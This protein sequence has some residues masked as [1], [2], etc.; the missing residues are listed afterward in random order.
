MLRRSCQL[1]FLLLGLIWGGCL[2]VLGQA[3]LDFTFDPTAPAVGEEVCFTAI[4][5]TGEPAWFVLFEWDYDQNGTYD[6]TGRDVCHSF[7]TEGTKTVTLRGT[8]DRGGFH[9][10]YHNVIVTN[11]QPTAE[12][13][14]EPTFPAAGSLVSF[15]GSPSFDADG[16][17]VSYEWDFGN[18]NDPGDPPDATGLTV[19]RAFATAGQHPVKL[20]V[21]DDGGA[22]GSVLH[23]VSVQPVSP[24]ACFEHDPLAPTVYDDILFMGDCSNDPDGGAIVLYSWSFGDG[25]FGTG[26]RVTHQYANGGVYEV[27]LTVTDDDQ[28]TDTT[29]E[30]IVVGGPS[31][32]FSYAPQS[33]TTQDAV[34]FFDQSSDTTG[35]IASW[36]WDFDDG[37]GSSVQNP[38]H[39]FA[40]SGPHRVR[41]T[42]TSE[43]GATSSVMR[44]ITVRNSPPTANYTFA[45]DTPDIDELVTFSAGGSS[46]PDGTIV[47]YEWDFDGDGLTDATGATVTHAFAIVG[48]RP[49]RLT[50][51]DNEGAPASLT[52]VVPV[53][54]SPPTACFTFTPPDPTTGEA[55]AFEGNCSNDAD[56]T[57]ILYEWDFDD[58]GATD[59]TGMAVTH[60]F[61]AAG[62]Y[63][64]TLMVTDNDGA[65]DADT[66]GVPVAT[67]GTSG[68]NQPPDPDFSITF[69]D[70]DEANIGEV[71][72]FLSDGSSDPDGTIVSYEWDFDNDGVYDATGTTASHVYH[73]GGAK[74]VTLRATD[75]D[76]AFGYKTRVVSVEFVRPTADFTFTPAQ[77]R[78]G[79]VVQ[80]DASPSTDRDGTVEFF[81]WDFDDDGQTDATG[82]TVTHVFPSGGAMPVTLTVIDDDGV[83]DF[84]TRTV[85]VEQNSPPVAD[86]T[87]EPTN[88]I[89]D[90][91]V[92]FRSTSTDVDGTIVAYHWDFGDDSPV[93]TTQTPSHSFSVPSPYTVTLT[94]TD[95][96][97]DTSQ[98][99]KTVIVYQASAEDEVVVDFTWSPQ[100]P[101]V[102]QQVQFSDASTDPRGTIDEWLW[103]FGD[104]TTS[105]AQDPTHQYATG[106]SYT[107][108]L[109]VTTAGGTQYP[110]SGPKTYTVVVGDLELYAFPNPT[111]VSARIVLGLARDATNIRLRIFDLKGSPVLDVQPSDGATEYL[112]NLQDAG[113]TVVGNGL[114][115]VLVTAKDAAGRAIRSEIFRLLIAR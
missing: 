87:F 52:K 107:V 77:P 51:T 43:G 95:D 27:S 58:D 35:D 44:T 49:V 40:V 54:A 47:I 37:G 33:P 1:A 91:L 8:D 94:I 53:Q 85:P 10:V 75:D 23:T 81:E 92:Q 98:V 39:V 7:P 106:G 76:G 32:A 38:L 30:T 59:A 70:G 18:D 67:G 105:T 64:V 55:V 108:T 115:F 11:E 24:I 83:A 114:Y 56:G 112:W 89:A 62:V 28:Q 104:G 6:A 13:T 19:R 73:T 31:A 86:F 68:D 109:R 50:V 4:V 97:G 78:N 69:A 93:T 22:T 41:L 57:I 80:F 17:I 79:E 48:A 111:S 16:V 88:P 63:P 12:F 45:P 42:V 34:Q 25:Q 72:T 96:G 103:N 29:T 113:G 61:P 90:Q 26:M 5:V 66:Q 9:F 3:T 36:T 46:D 84:T 71:V 15:D 20:T 65:V 82:M 60:S 74:I 100:Q 110:A 102:G 101:A 21:T 14:H 99:T 2:V